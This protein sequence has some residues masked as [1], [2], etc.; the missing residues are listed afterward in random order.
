MTRSLSL[1]LACLAAMFLGTPGDP[2]AVGLCASRVFNGMRCCT[3]ECGPNPGEASACCVGDDV[4]KIP[5]CN[6]PNETRCTIPATTQPTTGESRCSQGILSMGK[7]NTTHGHT[8]ICCADSC[9]SCGDDDDHDCDQRAGGADKCCARK[10]VEKHTT[11]INEADTGCLYDAFCR[12][13]WVGMPLRPT[14]SDDLHPLSLRRNR[15]RI[16]LVMSH[17]NT[18]FPYIWQL[19]GGVKLA[20]MLIISKCGVEPSPLPAN[21][22]A[23]VVRW[24]NVGG[25]DHSYAQWIASRAHDVSMIGPKDVV[26]FVKDTRNILHQG[27][28]FRY[29]TLPEIV[30]GVEATG[31]ACGIVKAGQR[32]A[33]VSNFAQSKILGHFKM[34]HYLKNKFV[35]DLTMAQWWQSLN[36][37]QPR[38]IPICYG[39]NFATTGARLRSRPMRFWNALA[40]SMNYGVYRTEDSSWTATRRGMGNQRGNDLQPSADKSGKPTKYYPQYSIA[41]GHYC[42]R[43]WASLLQEPIGDDMVQELDARSQ[44]FTRNCKPPEADTRNNPS[45]SNSNPF[46]CGAYVGCTAHDSAPEKPFRRMPRVAPAW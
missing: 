17:C 34:N 38:I 3:K 5:M 12:R 30:D 42:E 8:Q 27:A 10:I 1:Q 36:I 24:P 32:V 6:Y 18:P 45:F 11:C 21:S 9:G 43:T 46:M 2:V 44:G 39:G 26:L 33:P 25:C 41:E 28:Q 35:H 20:T 4:E 14:K 16:H 19:L 31:F 37:T 40:N 23:K 13:F 15:V 7:Y 22:I 29:Q